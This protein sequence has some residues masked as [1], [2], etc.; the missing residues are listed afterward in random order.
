MASAKAYDA[1][2]WTI[3]S[4]FYFGYINS[5]LFTSLMFD[6]NLPAKTMTV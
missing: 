6:D 4:S 1:V 2:S 5:Y 3:T